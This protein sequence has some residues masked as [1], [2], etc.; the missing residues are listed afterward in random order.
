MDKLTKLKEKVIGETRKDVKEIAR[1][2]VDTIQIGA[3][4]L[5]YLKPKTSKPYEI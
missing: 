3:C 4:A 1:K 2:A 5:Q